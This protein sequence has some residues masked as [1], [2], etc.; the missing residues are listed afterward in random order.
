MKHKSTSIVRRL[1]RAKRTFGAVAAIIVSASVMG[2]ALSASLLQEEQQEAQPLSVEHIADRLEARLHKRGLPFPSRQALVAA[3]AQRQQLLRGA[4]TA[5]FTDADG[6]VRTVA[7]SVPE[8]PQWILPVFTQQEAA[9]VI[10]RSRITDALQVHIAEHLHPPRH[11]V[12]ADLERQGNIMRARTDGAARSGDVFH[13]TGAVTA[14]AAALENGETELTIPIERQVGTV[15]NSTGTG[16]GQLTLLATGRSDFRG[17]TWARM[18]NVRKALNEHVHNVLV[19]PGEKFSFNA[20]L[21]GPVTTGNGWHMA[22]VIVNGVD[23]V[24]AP[25]GGICQVSTTTFR[26]IVNAGL[27]ARDWKAHSL[28]VS[29]YEHHGVGLDATVFPG[30]QDL[31]FVN[32]TGDYLLLQAYD[33]G[34]DAYVHIYGTPDGRNVQMDGPYFTSAAPP[35]LT[36]NGRGLRSNEIAWIQ[37]IIRPG[38]EQEEHMLVARYR[39]MPQNLAQKYSPVHAS[40][41]EP[42]G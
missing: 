23:L 9:F 35:G 17:S 27:V 18:Q 11:V 19:P 3:V 12:I 33:D 40:A 16:L 14:I 38:G 29:Y 22:K 39:A 13:S 37:R 6:I 41:G 28:Y 15:I 31:T 4:V 10:D 2:A 42:N 21:Q 26:A 24:Y 20:T 25:G 30:A 8:D 5:H 1:L 34:Y 36:V 7:F 32:D